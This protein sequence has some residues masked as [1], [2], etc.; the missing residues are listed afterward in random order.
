MIRPSSALAEVSILQ[1]ANR[2]CDILNFV[3][4]DICYSALL[5]PSAMDRVSEPGARRM[6]C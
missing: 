1:L 3:T 6:R 4:K 2:G 5:E